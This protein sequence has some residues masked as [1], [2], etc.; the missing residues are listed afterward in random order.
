MLAELEHNKNRMSLENF[1]VIREMQT[2]RNDKYKAFKE[3]W[4][5]DRQSQIDLDYAKM[6][7][8]MDRERE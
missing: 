4:A 6:H 8:V 5:K 7:E 3:K 1:Q 2:E